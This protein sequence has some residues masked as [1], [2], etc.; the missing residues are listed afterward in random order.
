MAWAHNAMLRGLNALYLQAANIPTTDAE[1]FLFFTASWSAWVMHHHLIEE[2]IMFPSFESVQGVVPNSLQHNVEQHHSFAKGLEALH[3]YATATGPAGYKGNKV[4]EL[5]CE[6]A[7]S[8]CDH[9]EEEIDTLWKMDSVPA[10]SPESKTLVEIYK[11]CETEAAK[12]DKNVVP[13]MVLGLCDKTFEGGNDWPK[14]PIGSAYF[15]HYIFARKHRGA[16]RFLPC[17]SETSAN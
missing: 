6:F 15:V 3:T 12:Q 8:L 16:W 5:I 13:P 1:D 7:G 4:R 14:M 10:H 17:D 11:R 9:L 2:T